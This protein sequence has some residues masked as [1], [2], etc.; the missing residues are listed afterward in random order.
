MRERVAGGVLAGGD[1]PGNGRVPYR[2]YTLSQRRGKSPPRIPD[3]LHP[4]MPKE[5][6]RVKE[7][8]LVSS[9]KKQLLL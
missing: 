7:E 8:F 3:H 4:P 2:R 6:A 9:R 1:G 5:K